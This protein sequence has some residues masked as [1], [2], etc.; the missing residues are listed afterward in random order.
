MLLSEAP[1]FDNPIAQNT[2]GLD[3]SGGI[4]GDRAVSGEAAFDA[5]LRRALEVDQPR[6]TEPSSKAKRRSTTEESD[7]VTA[8][9]ERTERTAPKASKRSDGV[10]ANAAE[11]RAG[12][13]RVSGKSRP[14]AGARKIPI[15]PRGVF[16]GPSPDDA[17][18]GG[19]RKTRVDSG[20]EPQA[21]ELDAR[22]LHEKPLRA[23]RGAQMSGARTTTKDRPVIE[24]AAGRAGF[25]EA[26]GGEASVD[27]ESPSTDSTYAPVKGETPIG[28][29][30]EE[31]KDAGSPGAV[32]RHRDVDSS[33]AQ[34]TEAGGLLSE[35]SAGNRAADSM[36]G[37]RDARVPG[38]STLT[39]I[40]LRSA[41]DKEPADRP[42]STGEAS[43]R[44]GRPARTVDVGP[45]R[46]EGETTGGEAE[47]AV[48][49][50]GGARGGEGDAGDERD[51]G[52]EIRYARADATRNDAGPG[53]DAITVPRGFGRFV[54]E[55][56]NPDIVR[57][58]N[59]L[60]RTTREGEIRMVL[61]PEHLGNLR[62]RIRLDENRISGRIIVDNAAVKNAVEQGL[63][64]L[65]KAFREHG[66]ESAALDVT[67]SGERGRD[68]SG[69]FFFA[70]GG[71]NP[72]RRIQK[73]DEATPLMQS[74]HQGVINVMA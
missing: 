54:R 2:R 50:N 28:A 66:Y 20:R 19:E 32:F 57:Q 63:D 61:K 72:R 41:G 30:T 49:E 22:S 5:V 8:A 37:G 69:R 40:D 1:T 36:S 73:L 62:L 4:V 17:V 3:A 55:A 25:D 43:A 7:V 10:A 53:R 14:K 46:V 13:G 56:M 9:R 59:I 70:A 47:R 60:L 29:E 21:T 64:D 24:T 48:R 33:A 16:V 12:K 18:L 44:T 26:I 42:R 52:T 34:T 39:V 15:E 6:T 31:P 74:T 58:S 27:R 71:V 67:V 45:S 68:R 35:A 23:S 11:R 38:S 65:L 51:A